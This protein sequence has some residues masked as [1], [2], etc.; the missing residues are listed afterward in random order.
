MKSCFFLHNPKAG[1]TA[2]REQLARH[3][4]RASTAPAMTLLPN[5]YRRG[6]PP[7]I[8]QG[9][10]FYGDH[11]G[12]DD[13]LSLGAKHT[14]ITNFRHP[15]TRIL[16]LYNY[17]RHGVAETSEVREAPEYFAVRLAKTAGFA[18]FVAS[19]D[20]RVTTYTHDFHFRQLARSGWSLDSSAP[21]EE[22]FARVDRLAWYYVCEYPMLSVLWGR[23]ALAMPSLAIGAANVT[24]GSADPT[25]GLLGIDELT[26]A[27]LMAHNPRDLMVYA[28]A[29]M[30][31]FQV[32]ATL[33]RT[34]ARQDPAVRPA[35]ADRP[36]VN[37][38]TR[39]LEA[40]RA[41]G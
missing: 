37:D 21:V 25:S 24:P 26:F 34:E 9:Y 15:A 18:T 6:G 32:I 41:A 23:E 13:Y 38:T 29:L 17:F 39:V 2:V 8:P 22:V 31:F 35:R 33:T 5:V 1:G 27:R 40:G 7:E 12:Y 36:W 11:F 19:D 3:F 28:H 20:P 4:G 14:L 10:R 16:S 30:R